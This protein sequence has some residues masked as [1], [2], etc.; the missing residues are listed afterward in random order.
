MYIVSQSADP[1][2]FRGTAGI[3]MN[4]RCGHGHGHGKV[5]GEKGGGVRT[6]CRWEAGLCLILKIYDSPCR[7]IAL[8]K[9]IIFKPILFRQSI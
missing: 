9:L 6:L 8:L 5:V 3:W 7:I 4:G 1:N 2:N